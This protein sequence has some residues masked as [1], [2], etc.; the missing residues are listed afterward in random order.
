MGN[1]I[2]SLATVARS[3]ETIQKGIQLTSNNVTN[4]GAPGY[5]RQTLSLVGLPLELGRG[6][7]G[8]LDSNGLISSRREY[9]EHGV[10]SQ[11]QHYNRFAQ[12]SAILS[13]LETLFDISGQG[14]P[15]KA[16][17]GLF[18]SFLE[19]SV[20]PNSTSARENVIRQATQLAGQLRDLSASLSN[21]RGTTAR[22]ARGTVNSINQITADLRAY[23]AQLRQDRRRLKDPGLDAQIHAKLDELAELVDYTVLRGEDGSFNVYVGGQTPVVLGDHHYPIRFDDSTGQVVILNDQDADITATIRSG[24]LRGLI[25]VHNSQIQSHMGELDVLAQGIADAVN[26]QLAAGVDLSNQPGADLF[27][28]DATLGVAASIRTSPIT[29]GQ[30]AAAAPAAPGG[31]T[32]ALDLA[33]LASARLVGGVSFSQFFGEL[34][35]RVGSAVSSARNDERTHSLMLTQAKTLREELTSVS[36]DEE[37]ARLVEFQRAYEASAQVFRALDELTQVTLNLVR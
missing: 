8:G 11:L 16:I 13:Q 6:L 9:L 26:G 25:E 22:E 18:S 33:D 7:V 37:A 14:G 23:N 24:K 5:A 21:A 29:A 12:K 34:A 4:A 1:L 28:Y 30:I 27:Q 36:L 3:M 15:A 20:A 10:Q 2:N 35:A 17:E 32:N 31:N 19:L